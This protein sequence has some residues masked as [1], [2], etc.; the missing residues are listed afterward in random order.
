MPKL[1]EKNGAELFASLIN[2]A[3]PVG[4]LV[5]DEALTQAILD[6]YKRIKTEKSPI[7]RSNVGVVM[8]LYADIVPL[9]F[10][11]NHRQ[12]ILLILSEI[13]G[14]AVKDMLEMN[15]AD[16]VADA[17]AAWK[18]QL[19]PFFKRAGLTGLKLL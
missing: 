1:L 7:K 14:C 5:Q 3:G 15:G 11:E 9:L 6:T 10:T 8:T 18:E 16:L 17:I 13:E 2:I 12:D 4:N 19:G